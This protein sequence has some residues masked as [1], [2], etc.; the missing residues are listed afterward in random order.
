MTAE[1]VSLRM[2]RDYPPYS[3]GELVEAPER[4]ALALIAWSYAVRN[5]SPAVETA[6]LDL[7]G[8][9]NAAAAPRRRGRP[10]KNEG[11]RNDRDATL[12]QPP[13]G[14]ATEG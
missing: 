4:L 9:Q 6:T 14:D 7:S 10:R 12:P 5:E 11:V 8:V 1:T 13:A 2:T 3:A